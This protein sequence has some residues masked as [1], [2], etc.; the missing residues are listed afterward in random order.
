MIYQSSCSETCFRLTGTLQD[1]K[2]EVFKMLKIWENEE[3]LAS[4]R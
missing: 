1:I 2:D 3:D 4:S